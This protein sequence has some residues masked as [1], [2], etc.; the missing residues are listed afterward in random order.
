[1]ICGVVQIRVNK[2]KASINPQQNDYCCFLHMR[3]I[4]K[5]DWNIAENVI[6]CRPAAD[7]DDDDDDDDQINE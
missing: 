6:C 5:R 4:F 7:D 2:E 1:M 3:T